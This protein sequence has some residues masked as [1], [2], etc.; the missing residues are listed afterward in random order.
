MRRDPRDTNKKLFRLEHWCVQKSPVLVAT[1]NFLD[2]SPNFL[3]ALFKMWQRRPFSL[4]LP[5]YEIEVKYE[6]EGA[7]RNDCVRY[8]RVWRFDW[9]L[10]LDSDCVVETDTLQRLLAHKLRGIVGAW[11]MSHD[12]SAPVNLP[13]QPRGVGL[14]EVEWTGIS[15][16][17]IHR[18]VLDAIGDP[19]F[20]DGRQY[21][22]W[23]DKIICAKAR[24]HHFPVYVDTE[25]VVKLEER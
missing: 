3:R 19:W 2:A 18:S 15:C 6:T 22:G 23:Q 10:F 8:A 20:R 4:Y 13:N 17:L 24:A 11:F 25:C 12:G 9:L 1:P 5:C 7:A 14:R 21:R 16:M